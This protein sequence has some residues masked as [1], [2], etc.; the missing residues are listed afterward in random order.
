[1]QRGTLL[2]RPVRRSPA[3][4]ARPHALPDGRGR[5]ARTGMA[6]EARRTTEWACR[7]VRGRG[8]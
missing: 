1:M 7:E 6:L 2:P 8:A 4:S 3:A 5:L